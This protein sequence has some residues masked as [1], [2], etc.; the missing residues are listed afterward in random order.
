MEIILACV[1]V[2]LL[3]AF[4]VTGVLKGQLK[5]VRWE[6]QAGNYIV[7]GSFDLTQ[8]TD[9]YLYRNVTRTARPKNKN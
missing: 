1:A 5:T 4:V 3:V 2:G 9:L 6:N 7:D 8:S